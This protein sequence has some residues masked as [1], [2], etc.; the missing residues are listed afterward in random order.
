MAT[1]VAERTRI[2]NDH[3]RS[4]REIEQDIAQTRH[5]MDHTLEQLGERLHPK[6]LLDH[7]IDYFRSPG[8]SS[9]VTAD[10]LREAGT[11]AGNQVS[12]HPVPFA[13]IGAGIA[14]WLAEGDKS[15]A[16]H[17]ASRW[18]GTSQPAYPGIQREPEPWSEEY[19]KEWDRGV[20]AW[21]PEYDWSRSEHDEK[22]WKERA[23]ST[24]DSL[25]STLA[26]SAKPAGEKVR[27]AATSLL[28][29]SGNRREAIHARWSDLREHSG[30]FVDAR[31]GEP[32]D[33]SYGR[34]WRN[35]AAADYL[36]ETGGQDE[37]ES[38][39]EKSEH[40]VKD[41][42]D[43]IAKG[44]ENVRDT[45]RTMASKIGDF[46]S[47]TAG[48]SSHYAGR[49]RRGTERMAGQAS[50][51]ATRLASGARHM[52][53]RV[54]E[55]VQ[56]SYRYTRHQLSETVEEYPLA[57]GV[58]ALGLGLVAGFLLPRSR[59]EDRWVGEASHDV[60]HRA[61]ET[62]EEAVHRGQEVA[63]TTAAAAMDEAERQGLTPSQ[64]GE[65]A[66]TAAKDVQHKT[67]EKVKETSSD[68]ADRTQ[69]VADRAKEAARSETERQRQEFAS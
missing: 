43:S 33:E 67:E 36:A 5:E 12:Q 17:G 53:G 32:Y 27:H 2:D 60:K 24:L 64:L 23:R 16:Q 6:H 69:Q 52:G 34:E 56:G 48:F 1:Q 51:G 49:A 39:K 8:T 37:S 4:S 22:S 38:W 50:A 42:Q 15:R 41:L 58:A 46:G 61:K 40:F 25:K 10:R 35:L 11:V 54:Q 63:S 21:H 13:L 30:S 14:W 3:R 65:K 20:A 19:A 57:A 66:R 9:R 62:A 55:R 59:T 28:A 47:S 45:L 26:D 7:V 29:L 44:G 31:T 18:P 68:L